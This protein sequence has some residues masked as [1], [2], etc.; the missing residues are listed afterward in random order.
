MKLLGY[1]IVHTFKNC[2]KKLFKTWVAILLV[3]IVACGVIGGFVGYAIGSTIEDNVPVSYTH[4]MIF[5][6]SLL[7][8]LI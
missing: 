3:F 4:L 5:L 2:I 8:T 7:S 1:Y 6:S